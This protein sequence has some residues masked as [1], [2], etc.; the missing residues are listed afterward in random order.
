LE[1]AVEADKIVIRSQRSTIVDV[2][3]ILYILPSD[4]LNKEKVISLP[5]HE[6]SE[7]L[8]KEHPAT[9]CNQFSFPQAE[10]TLLLLPDDNDESQRPPEP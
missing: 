5:T 8:T 4:M 7:K 9:L 1:E 3:W 2:L 6:Q 10:V